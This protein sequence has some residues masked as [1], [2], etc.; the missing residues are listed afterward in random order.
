M[1][2]LLFLYCSTLGLSCEDVLVSRGLDCVCV[3]LFKMYFTFFCYRLLFNAVISNNLK[4]K[5]FL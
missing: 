5:L 2:L 4:I 1:L 3:V